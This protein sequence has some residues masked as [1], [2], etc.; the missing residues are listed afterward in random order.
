L[1]K[2]DD[3]EYLDFEYKE[4]PRIFYVILL[5]FPSLYISAKG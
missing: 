5:I 1:D 4:L 3:S 2:K